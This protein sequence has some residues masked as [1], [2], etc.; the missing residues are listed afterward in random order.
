M[1][2][3]FHRIIEQATSGP[4][5]WFHWPLCQFPVTRVGLAQCVLY[6]GVCGRIGIFTFLSH[7]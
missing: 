4:S 5:P 2:K 3:N 7:P 1:E 6:L